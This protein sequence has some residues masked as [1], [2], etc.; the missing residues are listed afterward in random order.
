M[1][2]KNIQNIIKK[3][4]INN[5]EAFKEVKLTEDE[6][7]IDKYLKKLIQK[8]IKK[9]LSVINLSLKQYNIEIKKILTKSQYF[10][11]IVKNKKNIS[12]YCDLVL[13]YVQNGIK[14]EYELEIK[15]TNKNKIPGSSIQQISPE[16]TVIFFKYFKDTVEIEIGYY[17]QLVED[18]IPFPD[19]SPRPLISFNALK[20]SNQKLDNGLITTDEL[21]ESSQSIFED[22][23][24]DNMSSSWIDNFKNRIK[25]NSWFHIAMKKFTLKMLNYYNTLNE[26][27]KE[28]YL[29]YLKKDN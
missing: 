7:N 18:H 14:K 23:W 27:E 8:T 25:K 16:K 12:K 6:L 19:R 3:S 1:I 11:S 21:I 15:K 17:F 22:N 9:D 13:I 24:I 26:K 20:E 2:D 10:N 29:E 5:I 28:E 4:L